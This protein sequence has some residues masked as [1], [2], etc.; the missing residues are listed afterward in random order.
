MI[1]TGKWLR[2]SS[3]V[4]LLKD[5]HIIKTHGEKELKTR[6]IAFILGFMFSVV[7]ASCSGK[8]SE[9]DYLPSLSITDAQRVTPANEVTPSIQTISTRFPTSTSTTQISSTQA[10]KYTP[11]LYI[12]S[13]Q[14][15][16]GYIIVDVDFE[17]DKKKNVFEG[18]VLEKGKSA[19]DLIYDD[20]NNNSFL[21]NLNRSEPGLQIDIGNEYWENFSL[22]FEVKD[23]LFTYTA[24]EGIG[25]NVHG[26]NWENFHILAMLVGYRQVPEAFTT[27]LNHAVLFQN[28]R[29]D[30]S[31]VVLEGDFQEP[32]VNEW[33]SVKIELNKGEIS[34]Y[35]NNEM[36]FEYYDEDYLTEGNVTIYTNLGVCLDNIK[37]ISLGD[38]D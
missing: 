25:I 21:C 14:F 12:T 9:E 26:R 36:V 28:T 6:R 15:P 3:S 17:D 37:V 16:K 4:R 30:W 38:E 24:N 23:I 33:Y 34:V 8:A 20:G 19:W 13:T 29:P 5:C 1:Y 31:E 7:F 10:P 35:W 18:M 32:A 11:T 22:E 2:V 27:E